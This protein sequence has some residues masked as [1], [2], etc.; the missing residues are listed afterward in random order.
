MSDVRK[1]SFLTMFWLFWKETGI[2]T[3][4]LGNIKQVQIPAALQN[5]PICRVLIVY[6]GFWTRQFCAT[7]ENSVVI[8]G[9]FLSSFLKRIRDD[10]FLYKPRV[11]SFH[12]F[13]IYWY[14]WIL[15]S[16]DKFTELPHPFL[17]RGFQGERSLQ[18]IYIYINFNISVFSYLFFFPV[19]LCPNAGH[20]LFILEVSGSHT[21]TQHSR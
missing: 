17:T 3:Q 16:F 5:K 12:H 4:F 2:K 7:L 18:E 19:V 8:R 11:F 10:G 20:G 1:H 9:I 14:Y 6:R 13:F 21:T 15:F